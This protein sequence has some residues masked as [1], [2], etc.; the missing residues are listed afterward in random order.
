DEVAKSSYSELF[1]IPMGVWGIGYFLGIILLLGVYLFKQENP[2]DTFQTYG[3][4]VGLGVLVSV[5]LAVISA[6]FIKVMC[7]SCIGIYAVCLRKALAQFVY[8]VTLPRQLNTKVIFIVA[9]LAAMGVIVAVFGNQYL[10]PEVA[11]HSGDCRRNQLPR[12]RPI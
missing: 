11:G 8:R 3:L 9:S 10:N 4:M 5:A 7:P 1:N 12:A 2:K 6:T